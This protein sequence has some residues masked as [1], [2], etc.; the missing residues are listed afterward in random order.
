MLMETQLGQSV[1]VLRATSEREIP[2]QSS[3]FLVDKRPQRTDKSRINGIKNRTT[4]KTYENPSHPS[5]PR[6]PCESR[7]TRFLQFACSTTILRS[8]IQFVVSA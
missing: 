6:N 7:R 2:I 5:H 8:C 4:D 1:A 3:R